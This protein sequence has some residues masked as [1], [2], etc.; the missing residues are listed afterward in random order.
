MYA[1]GESRDSNPVMAS[2]TLPPQQRKDG[3][4][5]SA[6][7][8]S[9]VTSL[10]D[11]S[12]TTPWQPQTLAAVGRSGTGLGSG[13]IKLEGTGALDEHAAASTDGS[14]AAPQDTGLNSSEL[15]S[16]L[17]TAERS[18]VLDTPDVHPPPQEQPH[19]SLSQLPVGEK[20]NEPDNTSSQIITKA[21]VDNT[22]EASLETNPRADESSESNDNSKDGLEKLETSDT[23]KE[24]D[25]REDGDCET[26]GLGNRVLAAGSILEPSLNANATQG[27]IR[28][29]ERT[30]LTLP[31]PNH[32]GVTAATA[33]EI[34]EEPTGLDVTTLT[35]AVKTDSALRDD[36]ARFLESAEA[37]APA[38]ASGGKPT[39]AF[40]AKAATTTTGSITSSSA[41]T[42]TSTA[43]AA[44]GEKLGSIEDMFLPGR[45]TS[46][47][48]GGDDQSPS[49][50]DP[51]PGN[52]RTEAE[53]M[54]S[55][56]VGSNPTKRGGGHPARSDDSTT[57]E[58]FELPE[59][60]QSQRII[61]G[62]ETK[63]DAAECEPQPRGSGVGSGGHGSDFPS[64]S[65]PDST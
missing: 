62:N 59:G 56:G 3:D 12:S 31:S 44:A 24:N 48:V 17:P 1:A 20:S 6:D 7:S 43:K 32:V 22:P 49:D 23:K 38:L 8:Q 61:V 55:Q 64:L 9:A 57:T 29:D 60:K 33:V 4:K 51:L 65:S 35:E 21:G 30:L 13:E 28:T 53:R 39:V 34:P 11:S 26:E 58:V 45:E 46:I 15:V 25:E 40:R 14:P 50:F 42:T 52:S 41:A 27:G 5:S 37:V 16:Q 10:A 18:P 2:L 36:E 54:G 19:K 63:L 47:R